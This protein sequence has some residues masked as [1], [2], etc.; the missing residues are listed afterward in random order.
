MKHKSIMLV[1]LILMG[2]LFSACESSD[3]EAAIQASGF[4]EA[5]SY[6]VVSLAEGSVAA[7]EVS[8]G[9]AVLEG[10][11]L[12]E[13]ELDRLEAQRQAAAAGLAMAEA[14]LDHLER[15]PTVAEVEARTAELEA[16]QVDLQAAETALEQLEDAYGGGQPPERLLVPTQSVVDLAQAAV[17]LAQARLDQALAGARSEELRIAQAAVNEAQAMLEMAELEWELAGGS[18]PV[19]GV[20][21]QIGVHAGELVSPGTLLATVADTSQMFIIVYLGQAQVSRIQIGDEVEVGVDAYPEEV[22]EG[23]VSWIADEAQFT[24]TTVQTE[25]ERVAIVYAVR[26]EIDNSDNR[27]IS[28]LPADVVILP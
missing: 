2:G 1:A 7:V 6:R 3:D 22:F 8:R 12:V 14:E 17:D 9:D 13:L 5:R 27:L 19:D 16:A 10:Q 20:V 15:A 21:Q 28:G 26:I 25:E 23:Q 18:S 24:P 4:I 11:G